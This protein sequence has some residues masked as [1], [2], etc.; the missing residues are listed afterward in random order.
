MEALEREEGASVAPK[1]GGEAD[2][3]RPTAAERRARGTL[4]VSAVPT[5]SV[6]DQ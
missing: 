5:L 3:G 6:G 2:G 1:S 4:A